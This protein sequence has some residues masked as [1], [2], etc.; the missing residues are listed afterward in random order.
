MFS[1]KA[2]VAGSYEGILE[3]VIIVKKPHLLHLEL[4]RRSK[5]KW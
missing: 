3:I 5:N 2:K 1:N 4:S